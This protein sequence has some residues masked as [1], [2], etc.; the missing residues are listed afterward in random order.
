MA[1]CDACHT[2]H[3]FSWK[4]RGS[5]RPARPAT[6]ASIIRSGKCT[7]PRSMACAT[8]SS[9]CKIQTAESAAPTCQTCHMQEGNHEVRTAWGFLAVRLP[10]PEDPAVGRRPRHRSCRRSACSIPMA[11][12]PRCS[13][14][15]KPPTSRDSTQDDWQNRAR[16]NGQDLQPVPLH[17]FR[18]RPAR[19]GRR[20]DPRTLIT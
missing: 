15:S 7:P 10:M 3:T 5:R 11:N 12:P 8:C 16:Q 14:W 17:Q 6:W 4:K 18:Q 20:H 9:S 13:T 19:A 1:S 2:R